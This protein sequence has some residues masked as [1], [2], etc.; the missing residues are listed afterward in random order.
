[1]LINTVDLCWF[2][3]YLNITI[4]QKLKTKSNETELILNQ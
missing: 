1:M 4:P 3:K 2:A